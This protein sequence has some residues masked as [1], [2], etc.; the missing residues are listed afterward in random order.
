MIANI[1]EE[2]IKRNEQKQQKRTKKSQANDGTSSSELSILSLT[3]TDKDKTTAGLTDSDEG[4]HETEL[5]KEILKRLSEC[6]KYHQVLL[7]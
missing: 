6:V 1:K 7:Q 5:H 2:A 4:N 3:D